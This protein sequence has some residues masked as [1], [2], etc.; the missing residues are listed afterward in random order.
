MVCEHVISIWS[1]ASVRYNQGLYAS[2]HGIRDALDIF[3]GNVP[4]C[5]L[6]ESP[7]SVK[8]RY[9]RTLTNKSPINHI[10][11]MFDRRHVWRTCRAGK[12]WY[13]SSLEEGLHNLATCG[14]ALTCWNMACEVAWRKGSTSGFSG[15]CSD[16]S[17]YVGGE[18]A[19]CIQW[20]PKPLR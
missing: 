20:R 7:Q 2:W 1:E 18:I 5:S 13:L 4:P 16:C 11:D 6:Y 3:L 14:R 12:Q 17:Q 9:W 15:C 19:Y 10:P 8:S